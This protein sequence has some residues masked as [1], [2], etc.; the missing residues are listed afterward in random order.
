[1][2]F[3]PHTSKDVQL[4]QESLGISDTE[5]LFEEIPAAL[6]YKELKNI[7]AGLNEMEVL[8]EA[9]RF[10]AQNKNDLCFIGAG[11][12]AHYI[13]AAVWDLASRGE[14]LTAY[15]PYQA[16]ASQGTLQLLYE[17]QTMIAE[18]TGMDVS[19][20]SL[21]DGASALA[22]AVLMAMRLKKEAPE[23]RVLVAGS[24]HPFY[25]Q[26]LESIAGEQGIEFF[27]LDFDPEKGI[28]DLSILDSFIVKEISALV[29]AQP[30]FFGCLEEVDILTDWAHE[31]HLLCIA[32]VN[33]ISLGLLKPPGAWGKKGA[34]IVCGEGQPLGIPMAA[35]GPYFGFFATRMEYVRQVPGRIIG[36]TVDQA[37][38][39]GYSLTLQAREQH[40]RR[41]KA[42]S[43]ICTNQGLMVTAASIYMSLMGAEGLRLVAEKCHEN[44]SKLLTAL[45][46][47]PGIRLLF[48]A[49]YFHE[50]L[51]QIEGKKAAQ[52]LEELSQQHGI[53]G[54]YPLLDHF[55][56]LGETILL[57][58][59]ELR[60]DEE[61]A[62]YASVLAALVN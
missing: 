11:S 40:I 19:N 18:L 58:A 36:R 15:T 52:V 24:L 37:G 7:P 20:A 51:I 44:M 6:R 62:A 16:E 31:H 48:S 1:M 30:N 2:P 54:G 5:A 10:A 61:I 39:T 35:G 32:C 55:P 50:A 28:C 13:P 45:T 34:D 59:T 12:Y 21:Y 60:T 49:P 9:K 22:E 33:P 38:K 53:L 57:C 42:T 43:N 25:R 46:A 8:Q 29:I 41:A 4:M 3:I 14:F 17:F 47:I 26:T 27:T 23:R 56:D